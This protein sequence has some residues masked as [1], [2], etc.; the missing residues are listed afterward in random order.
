MG[1]RP[2][3]L[4]AVDLVKDYGKGENLVHALRDVSVSFER[5]AFTAIMGPSGSGKSTLMHTLAGL[6]SITS[7]QIIFDGQDITDFNDKQLT[8]LRR[9]KVGFIFQSFNLL[10]MFD[11][12]QNIFMP[13]TLA[14][15]RVDKEWFDLLVNTLGLQDRLTH[16]PAEMSGGQQ[17][18]VAIARALIS[19]PSVIF[20]DEPTGNL[21]SV[22]SAEVLTLMRDLVN[23]LG[24]TIVMVTH[25][26]TAASYTDRA[27]ILADGQIVADREHPQAQE[28]SDL[29]T[30]IMQEIVGKQA[31][32]HHLAAHSVH[33]LN[34]SQ[35]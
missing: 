1:E 23:E 16:R 17:Q 28:M 12:R 2:I 31:S 34:A 33:S 22:S 18:R 8:L 4:R 21:D 3:A 29:L 6:D 25:D 27:I 11:A 30:S 5:G 15:K 26:A 14:N 32:A 7:G 9:E 20:A 19:K 35:A 10:P 24:Q 13:L